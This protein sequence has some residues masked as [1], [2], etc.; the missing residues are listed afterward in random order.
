MPYNTTNVSK[1]CCTDF[2]SR[3]YLSD[4]DLQLLAHQLRRGPN[5]SKRGFT[6][7][8]D[9]CN[10][11]VTISKRKEFYS[12]SAQ[13]D[14]R[15]ETK[16]MQMLLC[17][18]PY[19]DWNYLLSL[20]ISIWHVRHCIAICQSPALCMYIQFQMSS[21]VKLRRIQGIWQPWLNLYSASGRT[22]QC[23]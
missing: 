9:L 8:H 14:S 18:R 16:L 12:Y 19:L 1:V 11:T 22:F 2:N 10:K 17:S 20:T 5:G 13:D 23:C 6:S 7:S 3:N 15:I 4:V 21:S